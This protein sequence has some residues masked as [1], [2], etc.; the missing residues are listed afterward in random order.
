MPKMHQGLCSILAALTFFGRNAL[1]IYRENI[2]I[3][4]L[5]PT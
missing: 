1:L 5:K 3:L 4:D 2:R